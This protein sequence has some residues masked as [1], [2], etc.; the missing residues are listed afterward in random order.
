MVAPPNRNV[1]F[2]SANGRQLDLV[3][4]SGL[5]S[6]ISRVSGLSDDSGAGAGNIESYSYLGLGT[7]VQRN[8]PNGVNL[9]LARLSTSEGTGDGG[10]EY[11]GLDRFGRLVDQRWTTAGGAAADR[12][13]YGYDQ[14]GNV[15]Y[16][17]NLVF[18]LASELYHPNGTGNGLGYD[19][20][21]RITS[22]TRGTL[23]ASAGTLDTVTIANQDTNLPQHTETWNLDALGNWTGSSAT[24]IDGT[25]QNRTVDSRNRYTAV[26]SATVTSDN[27]GNITQD[28][29]G[30]K[31]VYDI[32]NRI[33]KV[34]NSSGSVLE[35]YTYDAFGR[36][37]TETPNGQT[38]KDLYFDGSNVIEEQ[39]AGTTT[40]QY[41]WGSDT[42]TAWCCGMTTAAVATMARLARVWAAGCL[43]SRTPTGISAASPTRAVTFRSVLSTIRT[44][45]CRWWTRRHG[46]PALTAL[47]GSTTSRAAAKTRS[48][49]LCILA[50]PGA[51]TAPR[52][53][54]G[55][56]LTAATLTGQMSTRA[57]ARTRWGG[58]IRRALTNR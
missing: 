30:L 41:V 6:N 51:I 52:W 39:Q 38:T 57:T 34:E 9:T 1:P 22:F 3:Y 47:T 36:R 13:Q 49:A 15:L 8:R 55:P 48:P 43:S 28:E 24:V 58:S 20:L 19:A 2:S 33:V 32:W 35:T 12:F 27:I 26:G 5:D 23:T 56:S 17:N 31:Y 10:D 40:N 37:I 18:S 46:T 4:N 7:I 50:R 21:N 45:G 44:A 53:A 25:N 29:T 11:I 54:G 14:D 16:K 42:S